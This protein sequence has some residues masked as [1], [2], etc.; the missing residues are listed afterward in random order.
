MHLET[1][2]YL[3]NISRKKNPLSKLCVNASGNNSNGKEIGHVNFLNSRQQISVRL[4]C[5]SYFRICNP[6]QKKICILKFG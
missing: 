6:K 5:E 3:K 4:L 2:F 1:F